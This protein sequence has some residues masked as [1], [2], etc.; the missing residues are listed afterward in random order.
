[1][2]GNSTHIL[3]IRNNTPFYYLYF[4]LEKENTTRCG[5]S[6]GELGI[7]T[8]GSSHFNGFQ[9]RRFRPLSQLSINISFVTF[10]T[11]TLYIIL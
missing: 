5:V 7:R 6:G 11:N 10:A 3:L 9:D 8:P 2:F 1:M 4:V